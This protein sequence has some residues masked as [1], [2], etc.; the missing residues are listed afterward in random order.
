MAI[1]MYIAFTEEQA[2]HIRSRGLTVIEYKR[3]IRKG[4][5]VI[6]YIVNKASEKITKALKALG[7]AIFDTVDNLKLL[8]EEFRDC[9]GY[10]TGRRYTV[11]KFLSE[12]GFDKYDM[13]KQ[14]RHIRLARSNC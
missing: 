8:F 3:C 9:F 7:K 12:C 1:K 2:V 6:W 10:D 11:V 13:W 5:D 14:T 4:I